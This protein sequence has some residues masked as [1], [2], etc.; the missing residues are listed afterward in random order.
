MIDPKAFIELEEL[1]EIDQQ[2]ESIFK[3][4]VRY[5]PPEDLPIR[6]LK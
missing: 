4:A 2:L 1:R 5:L 6:I 3:T